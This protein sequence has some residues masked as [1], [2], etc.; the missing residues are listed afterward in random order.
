MSQE[1]ER[2]NSMRKRVRT[3]NRVIGAVLISAAWMRIFVRPRV[4]GRENLKG[5][6]GPLILAV[7]H[8]SVFDIP[9]LAGLIS[10]YRRDVTFLAMAELF[11]SV[12][13]RAILNWFGIIPVYRGSERA[14]EASDRG[15][16]VLRH[17]GVVITF[18][19]GKISRDGTLQKARNGVSYMALKA[20][21]TVVPIA[22]FG[23]ERVKRL[24]TSPLHWG[25]GK[26][27]AVVVGAPMHVE[28]N[29]NATGQD[30]TQL[31]ERIMGRITTQHERA[32]TLAA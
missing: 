28:Q 7:N 29:L 1:T 15:V 31:T 21:A 17:G 11:R 14:T 27:Y 8:L 10:R 32:R 19:E 3:A 13:M 30:R 2:P 24:R 12:I 18:I 23:T 9:A 6:N 25:W 22:L 5:L 4:E 16:I 26:R 20:G